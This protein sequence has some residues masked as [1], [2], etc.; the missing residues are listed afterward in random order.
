MKHRVSLS[1][2]EIDI[3]IEALESADFYSEDKEFYKQLKKL[4]KRLRS[5]QENYLAKSMAGRYGAYKMK[6]NMKEKLRKELLG[7]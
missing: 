6:E 2:E 1:D 3:I 7:V 5:V 4:K